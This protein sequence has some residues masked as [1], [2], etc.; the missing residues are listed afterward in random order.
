MF[1]RK[2]L[3]I[4][5]AVGVSSIASMDSLAS[6]PQRIAVFQVKGFS[7][8]TCATGLDTLLSRQ[9]GIKSSKSTY[10]EGMV[11]VEYLSDQINPDQIASFIGD[12]GFVATVRRETLPPQ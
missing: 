11:T 4:A 2:F 8:I 5:A 7:C 6:G 12:L 3:Q 9:K 10:P 1:R